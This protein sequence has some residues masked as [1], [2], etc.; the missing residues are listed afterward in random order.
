ME[1]I[2]IDTIQYC[3]ISVFPLQW[4]CDTFPYQTRKYER[5]D[6]YTVSFSTPWLVKPTVELILSPAT[7]INLSE[8]D[9]EVVR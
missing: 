6:I 4:I 2:T 9:L 8:L 1:V 5:L 3:L 7:N